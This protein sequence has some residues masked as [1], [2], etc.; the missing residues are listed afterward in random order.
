M[1]ANSHSPPP[2]SENSHTGLGP[3]PRGTAQ[4]FRLLLLAPAK[5]WQYNKIRIPLAWIQGGPDSASILPSPIP[6]VATCT[7]L[8]D[9]TRLYSDSTLPFIGPFPFEHATS[10]TRCHAKPVGAGG[11]SELYRD[12]WQVNIGPVEM[13][14]RKARE[15]ERGR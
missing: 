7:T 2:A 13:I 6:L 10:G 9:F 5:F 8:L 15:T 3:S 4:H 1:S 14:S 11:S 12:W